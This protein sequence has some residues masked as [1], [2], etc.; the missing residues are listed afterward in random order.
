MESETTEAADELVFRDPQWI[1]ENGGFLHGNNGCRERP[2]MLPLQIVHRGSAF[3][4]F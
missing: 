1:A 3:L 4:I 2:S